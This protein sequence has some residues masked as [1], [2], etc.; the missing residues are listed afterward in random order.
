[1]AEAKLRHLESRPTLPNFYRRSAPA[2]SDDPE[3]QL[4]RL[5]VKDAVGAYQKELASNGKFGTS[6][7]SRVG[8]FGF[9]SGASCAIH[10]E[11]RAKQGRSSS[12]R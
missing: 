8:D 4:V 3:T 12:V 10:Q 7:F 2:E 1:M 6:F 9:S 11:F 5:R